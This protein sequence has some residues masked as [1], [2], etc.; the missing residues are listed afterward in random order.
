MKKIIFCISLMIS[1]FVLLSCHDF[2]LQENVPVPDGYQRVV[3][4]PAGS[5]GGLA[6]TVIM[7]DLP[8]LVSSE[9]SQLF[10]K[11]ELSGSDGSNSTYTGSYST[12]VVAEL[13]T[14][15][16]Y[17]VTLSLV[18]ASDTVF[19]SGSKSVTPAGGG[20]LSE[21]IELLRV[22]PETDSGQ[23]GDIELKF[24]CSNSDFAYKILWP[25]NTTSSA[26]NKTEGAVVTVTKNGLSVGL[27]KVYFGLYTG[28]EPYETNI[29]FYKCIDV[30]VYAGQTSSLWING[31][32]TAATYDFA[33]E[34]GAFS[35][36]E[37]TYSLKLTAG[38]KEYSQDNLPAQVLTGDLTE[39]MHLQITLGIPGQKVEV[40][41]NN[42][43]TAMTHTVSGVNSDLTSTLD[44]N[45][46]TNTSLSVKVM[47][48]SPDN[49]NFTKR[50]FTIKN[51][52]A[53]SYSDTSSIAGL[54][55][56]SGSS[57][58]TTETLDSYAGLSLTAGAAYTIYT[59]EEL[60]QFSN[61]VNSGIDFSGCTVELKS[62]ISLEGIE[63]IPVG[64]YSSSENKPFKGTFDGGGFTVSDLNVDMSASDT[65]TA[66]FF[67]YVL[68]G[69][70]ENIKCSGTV[71]GKNYSG[72]IVGFFK[73]YDGTGSYIKNCCFDGNIEGDGSYAGGITG[74]FYANIDAFISGCCS[75]GKINC[76]TNQAAGIAAAIYNGK[77][78]NCNN[79]MSISNSFDSSRVAGG[80]VG[81]ATGNKS[82]QIINCVNYET[83]EVTGNGNSQSGG[84]LGQSYI[85][86]VILTNCVNF[87]KIQTSK[88]SYG[89]C[90]GSNSYVPVIT[91]CYNAGSVTAT[92]AAYSISGVK[93]A[94]SSSKC[95][96]LRD[97]PD[98]CPSFD[99]LAEGVCSTI[100]DA[101]GGT[102]DYEFF[103]NLLNITDG[104]G[105]PTYYTYEHNGDTY[106][107]PIECK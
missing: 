80:I 35:S 52:Y 6:K 105:N 104:D 61:L 26:N 63:W 13:K 45:L 42:S 47:V 92:S 98:P 12:G 86:G 43:D 81:T 93:L 46:G 66:G 17:T 25:D 7:P 11:A 16:T 41:I 96:Y 94:D 5:E 20:T 84:I 60:V 75:K 100:E 30:Y 33:G 103:K 56:W 38:G 74:Y 58:F 40:F 73:N 83:V 39:D 21:S 15:I 44:Y 99:E 65:D 32:D 22:V 70:I 18:N 79:R 9:S 4:R 37:T 67:G 2:H 91:N 48:Y 55:G 85:A 31:G 24:T 90:Y 54:L 59:K 57:A 77:V 78:E 82:S 29:S 69:K 14:G 23:T 88:Y 62:D 87:G 95:Y 10:L 36:S 3:F 8:S 34:E 106:P 97:G 107:V 51:P 50:S 19:L 68:E 101:C 102:Y 64:Y 89:I 49:A 76:A 53:L 1:L 27:H 72:G 28:E 71:K